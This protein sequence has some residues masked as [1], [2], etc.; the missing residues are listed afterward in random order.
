M[1]EELRRHDIEMTDFV[2]PKDGLTGAQLLERLG[3]PVVVKFVE[4]SGGRGIQFLSRAEAESLALMKK[5]VAER[6]LDAPEVSVESFI[7]RGKLLFSNVTSY[8]KKGHVNVVPGLLSESERES[9]LDLNERV[10]HALHLDWGITHVEIYL[11]QHGPLFG[12]IALRPPGGYIMQ[13]LE[14]AYGFD[15]WQA[16]SSVELDLPFEF[17]SK[18]K[19]SAAAIIW[20]PGPGTL[21][22]VPDV[23]ALRKRPEVKHAKLK[24][25]PGDRVEPRSGVGS[26]VGYLLLADENTNRLV[27]AV[28]ELDAASN[29]ALC[30]ADESNSARD[31]RKSSA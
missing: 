2:S 9:V 25:E 18:A 17:P 20:H 19:R 16:F 6:Y 14:L 24:V 29:A 22:S 27:E 30:L 8:L 13:L 15:A 26:D 11:T 3:E 4:E 10:I 21:K 23:R 31:G 5:Q 28:C 1:K 7:N 12:E